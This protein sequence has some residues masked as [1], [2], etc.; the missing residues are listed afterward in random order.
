MLVTFLRVFRERTAK[1]SVFFPGKWK[2]G[3]N[4]LI[5]GPVCCLIK[6]R[7]EEVTD[8]E[9]VRGPCF[10]GLAWKTAALL[11][12]LAFARRG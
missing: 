9:M 6:L 7:Q 12:A 11:S 5:G 10:L 2:T 1:S 8:G 4:L 3:G